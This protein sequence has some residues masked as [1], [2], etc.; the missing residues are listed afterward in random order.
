MP[1]GVWLQCCAP[2]QASA[3][4]GPGTHPPH[5]LNK[6]LLTFSKRIFLPE[7]KGTTIT[8]KVTRLFF[9]LMGTIKDVFFP[10]K[11][12]WSVE[13]IF[14][15]IRAEVNNSHKK[16]VQKQNIWDQ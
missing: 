6:I 9:I 14:L 7:L 15:F 16:L 4:G 8:K 1:S 10:L 2:L 12:L 5:T 13:Y 3:D 11:F